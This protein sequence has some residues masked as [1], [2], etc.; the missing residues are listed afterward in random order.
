ML[1]AFNSGTKTFQ[2]GHRTCKMAHL[3]KVPAIKFVNLCLVPGTHIVGGESR[4]LSSILYTGAH[5]PLL[6]SPPQNK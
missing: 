6:P 2:K 5:V 3:V 1:K 4:K